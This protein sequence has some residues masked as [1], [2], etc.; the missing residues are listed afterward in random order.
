MAGQ[1]PSQ[2][3][4]PSSADISARVKADLPKRW[5]ASYAPVRDAI[6]GGLAD[7]GAW[8]YSLI[9]YARQQT[10][11]AT[12]TGPWLDILAFDFLGLHL[13]RRALDDADFRAKIRATILQERVTRAGMVSA[14]TTLAGQAPAIFEPWNTGDAGAW[15]M[16]GFAWAGD[17]VTGPGGGWDE[18]SG[19][20]V[21]AS[22]YD[23]QAEQNF[24][25]SAGAGGWGSTDMPAQ[26]LI[27][28]RP[29]FAAAAPN[30]GGWDE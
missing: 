5:F 9:D 21:N 28:T 26:V 18:A 23:L 22:G 30:G 24:G 10:R 8:N 3:P 19:W 17:P 25:G 1:P 13:R 12:A 20:D 16:G 15:D 27:S 2:P 14:L 4:S 6:M 29:V 11:L 7:L